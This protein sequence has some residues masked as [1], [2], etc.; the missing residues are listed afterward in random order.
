MDPL[1]VLTHILGQSVSRGNGQGEFICGKCVSVLERVF[2]FDTVITRVR[3]LSRERL[4]KLAQ[5]RDNLRRWVRGVYRQHHPSELRNRGSS[6]EDDFDVRNGS[7][8]ADTGRAYQEMLSDNMAFSAYEC[9]S[10]KSESCPY[11]KRTGK[12]CKTKNCECCDSLRVS[13]SDYESVCGVPRHLPQEAFSPFG[14]SRDQSLSMPLSWS[15]PRSPHSSP[16]SL[17]GS[18]QS[19]ESQTRKASARSLDSLDGQDQFG[20]TEEHPV[21]FNSIL[22]ELRSIEGKPLMSPSGSRIPVLAKG[23]NG[24]VVVRSR[25]TGLERELD[26]GAGD[27]DELNGESDDVLTELRDEFLPLQREVRMHFIFII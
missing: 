17:A 13:D 1:A 9:W 23:Q 16:A 2:K 20:W 22:E 4:Q 6:S 15:K 3:V 5:E 27:E 14:L 11:F 7:S 10:E 24:T 21:I 18:C 12:Q 8:L 19:L 25:V 26:F